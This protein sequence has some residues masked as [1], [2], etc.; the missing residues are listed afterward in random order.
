MPLYLFGKTLESGL[1]ALISLEKM[2]GVAKEIQEGGEL[3]SAK[4]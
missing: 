3:M 4:A 2:N 1:N